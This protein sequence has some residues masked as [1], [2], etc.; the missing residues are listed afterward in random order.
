[1]KHE[2]S[3]RLGRHANRYQSLIGRNIEQFRPLLRPAHVTATAHRDLDPLAGAGKRLEVNLEMAGI[4]RL[5]SDPLAVRRKLAIA[6]LE[7]GLHE[8]M[9]GAVAIERHIPDVGRKSVG[10][11]VEKNGSIRRYFRWVD[12]RSLSQQRLLGGAC[13]QRP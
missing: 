1:M 9:R 2:L 3:A 5:I 6:F 7:S 8:R 12:H 4:I 13:D 11:G 10:P